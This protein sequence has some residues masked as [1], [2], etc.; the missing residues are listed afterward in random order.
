MDDDIGLSL[1]LTTLASNIKSKVFGV[2]DSF[3]SFLR[4][5]EEKKTHNMLFLMFDPRFKSLHLVSSY[6]G[7]EQRMFIVEQYDRRALYPM[8][9]K[10]YNHL[11]L[12]GNVASSF[13]DLNVDEDYALNIF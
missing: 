12:V 5:Y 4:T 8:L 9:I 11:H 1:K 7:K 13:V 3:L 10:L 2:L 6:V